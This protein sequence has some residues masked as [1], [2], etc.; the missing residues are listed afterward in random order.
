MRIWAKRLGFSGSLGLLVWGSYLVIATLLDVPGM[1]AASGLIGPYIRVFDGAIL[2]IAGVI[3]IIGS[4]L[5][6]KFPLT[7]GCLLVPVCF[8]LAL[9][10][11]VTF[12]SIW[13][14]VSIPLAI[15]L[16]VS[17]FMALKVES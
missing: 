9:A 8:V 1:R 12:P 14:F 5:V 2:I 10:V 17:C 3:T 6:T 13:L 11:A 16:I 7:G 4:L 15:T